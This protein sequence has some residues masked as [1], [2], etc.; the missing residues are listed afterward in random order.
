MQLFDCAKVTGPTDWYRALKSAE[1]FTEEAASGQ[2]TQAEG[3]SAQQVP[4]LQ[5]SGQ[6]RRAQPIKRA[7][8]RQR[9]ARQWSSVLQ[10]AQRLCRIHE[11]GSADAVFAD[12]APIPTSRQRVRQQSMLQHAQGEGL[13]PDLCQAQRIA[14]AKGRTTLQALRGVKPGVPAWQGAPPPV[15]D[16]PTLAP[17]RDAVRWQG[18]NI[19][20][21]RPQRRV[22]CVC[23]AA[24]TLHCARCLF[25]VLDATQVHIALRQR[26][27]CSACKAVEAGTQVMLLASRY[28]RLRHR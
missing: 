8:P 6:A 11:A 3:K 24:M 9:Q 22:C 2:A 16:A 21:I 7:T 27:W 17:T 18:M 26:R 12:V 28:R 14:G 1:A 25:C 5:S 13:L 10:I 23:G 4:Q 20:F 19:P 15:L